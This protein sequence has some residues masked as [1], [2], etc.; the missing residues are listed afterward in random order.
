MEHAKVVCVVSCW[1]F[2]LDD[3]LQSGRTV[4]V[5]GDQIETSIENNQCYTMQETANTLKISK[6]IKLL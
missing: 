3:A 2:L 4:E 5:D 1:R 6:S